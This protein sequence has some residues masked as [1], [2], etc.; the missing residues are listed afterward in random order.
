MSNLPDDDQPPRYASKN[1]ATSE[2]KLRRSPKHCPL[3]LG[4]LAKNQKRTKVMARCVSCRANISPGK[5]CRRC[6]AEAI[7]E[8]KQSAA[9]RA[10][11]VHGAKEEVIAS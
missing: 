2:S 9:C 10:C 3:C 5:S 1:R 11:G 8:N 4:E 7:W 6:L